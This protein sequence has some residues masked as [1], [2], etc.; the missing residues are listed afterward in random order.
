MF[1]VRLGFLGF[2][3]FSLS[4]LVLASVP[5][6][7]KNKGDVGPGWLL[8]LCMGQNCHLGSSTGRERD[9]GTDRPV[10]FIT[11]SSGEVSFSGVNWGPK[12]QFFCLSPNILSPRMQFPD[13]VSS[14]WHWLQ[15]VLCVMHAQQAQEGP[16]LRNCMQKGPVFDFTTQQ[17]AAKQWYLSQR[18][19]W[20]LSQSPCSLHITRVSYFWISAWGAPCTYPQ[21]LA[22]VLVL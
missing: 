15:S 20:P 2:D 6:G 13:H 21:Y 4:G 11:L 19:H 1:S 8:P 12:L 10:I 16:G 14:N 9:L 18:S 7:M 3:Y 5:L 22:S 17:V